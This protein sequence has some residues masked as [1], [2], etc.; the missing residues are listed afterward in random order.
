MA[1]DFEQDEL[2]LQENRH[3]PEGLQRAIVRRVALALFEQARL[4]G[5]AGLFE[6]P[7]YAQIA[8]LTSRERRNPGKGGYGDHAAC[9]FAMFA[10]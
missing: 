1:P 10:A 7:S 3:L 5:E 8:Y 9:S 2:V 6:R 4:V